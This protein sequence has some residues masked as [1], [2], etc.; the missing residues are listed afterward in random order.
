[1]T[2]AQRRAVRAGMV[3]PAG[4]SIAPRQKSGASG[5]ADSISGSVERIWSMRRNEARPRCQRFTTQPSATMGQL[6]IARYTVNATN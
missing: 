4:E 3:K 6:S 5:E 1:M 2:R